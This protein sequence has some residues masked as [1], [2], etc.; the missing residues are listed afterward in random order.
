MRDATIKITERALERGGTAF[1]VDAG[2]LNGKRHRKQFKT[3]DQAVKYRTSLRE[4]K[5]SKGHLALLLDPKQLVDAKEAHDLL[6]PFGISLVNA[7]KEYIRIAKPAGGRHTVQEVVNE[8]MAAKTESGLSARYLKDLRLKY[9]AF[10]RDFGPRNI[11]EVRAPEL[12]KWFATL[13]ELTALTRSNY[14][15]ELRT[16]FSFALK[17]EYCPVNPVLATHTPKVVSR[18]PK[19][20]DLFQAIDLLWAAW[21]YR[22]KFDLVPYIALGLF[23][24]I[25][26]A[27][28]ER[29]DWSHIDL[30]RRLIT[31][32]AAH[33][34][35]GKRRQVQ[36][37]PNLQRW[38]EP[39][40]PPR[41]IADHRIVKKCWEDH[42]EKVITLAG[43]QPWP[44]NALRK[45]FASY[46]FAL[47]RNAGYTSSEMGHTRQ[48]VSV[49]EN[50]YKNLVKPEHVE[51]FWSLVPPPANAEASSIW[52]APFDCKLP[53]APTSAAERPER[54]NQIVQIAALMDEKLEAHTSTITRAVLKELRSSK[55]LML[56][57]FKAA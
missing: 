30:S 2:L 55:K 44:R 3:R 37:S 15:R 7:A 8:L 6:A 48:D 22:Q 17:R 56:K 41:Q 11:A 51:S 52:E 40:A 4:A 14:R 27:E 33:A 53:Q 46:H 9:A 5:R 31:V 20:L 36:I 28:I 18:E 16:L 45:S 29:L 49:F 23:A 21:C 19:A 38:L 25:R 47:H 35:S 10:A 24:G 54:P 12:D 42:F 32:P 26:A 43:L 13:G 34:K 50:S 39:C 1:V 57:P